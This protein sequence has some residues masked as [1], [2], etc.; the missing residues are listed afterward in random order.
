MRAIVAAALTVLLLLVAAGPHVHVAGHGTE[1][2]AVCVARGAD[3]AE[4]Q[5]PD[6]AP[7]AVPAGDAP[8]APGPAPVDGAPLGAIPGQSPPRA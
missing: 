3:V 5:T 6:V 1:E 4:P 8:L 7:V 2:C